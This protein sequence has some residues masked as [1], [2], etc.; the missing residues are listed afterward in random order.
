MVGESGQ[1]RVCI[2]SPTGPSVPN[3][4]K[5]RFRVLAVILHVL[6]DVCPSPRLPHPEIRR[7]D[8]HG[9]DTAF[10]ITPPFMDTPFVPS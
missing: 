10:I 6:V 4:D 1:A 8:R 3:A 9:F 2:G 7:L 5:I